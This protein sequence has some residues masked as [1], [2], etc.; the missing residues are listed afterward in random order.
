MYRSDRI[1][2]SDFATRPYSPGDRLLPYVRRAPYPCG[3]ERLILTATAAGAPYEV[4]ALAQQLPDGQYNSIK[5]VA[6]AIDSEF[7]AKLRPPL[8][9]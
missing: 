7:E 1:K 5:S 3:R 2:T 4:L 9:A 6:Y 8:A